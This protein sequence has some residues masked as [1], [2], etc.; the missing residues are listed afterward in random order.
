MKQS[1]NNEIHVLRS[2][3]AKIRA[4]LRIVAKTFPSAET[5]AIGSIVVDTQDATLVMQPGRQVGMTPF[6]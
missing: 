3:V 6:R 5:V 2:L 1:A 4:T